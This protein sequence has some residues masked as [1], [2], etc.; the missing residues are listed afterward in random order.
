MISLSLYSSVCVCVSVLTSLMCFFVPISVHSSP[1]SLL[2]VSHCLSAAI[3]ISISVSLCLSV[4]LSLSHFQTYTLF[5]LSNSLSPLTSLSSPFVSVGF[6]KTSSH[7]KQNMSCHNLSE[8]QEVFWQNCQRQGNKILTDLLKL[9]G[10]C[11]FWICKLINDCKISK[12]MSIQI[13]K[14]LLLLSFCVQLK[15]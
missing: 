13:A 8:I 12:H 14:Y 1:F 3:I 15:I 5:F 11:W 6:R 9:P 10:W 2:L 7:W 4:S